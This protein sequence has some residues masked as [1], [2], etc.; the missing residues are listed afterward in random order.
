MASTPDDA[1][2]LHFLPISRVHSLFCV[3]LLL[4]GPVDTLWWFR[5]CLC[6]CQRRKELIWKCTHV[7]GID[8]WNW[9]YFSP[10]YDGILRKNQLSSSSGEFSGHILDKQCWIFLIP[11]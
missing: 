11:Q 10:L 2:L 9:H 5:I 7:D 6:L 3:Q 8:F 1:G 4:S